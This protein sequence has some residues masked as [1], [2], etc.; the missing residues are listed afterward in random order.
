[1]EKQEV[2]KNILSEKK[3]KFMNDCF[4]ISSMKL[5]LVRF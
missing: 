2:A 3:T 4:D 1:M 5:R